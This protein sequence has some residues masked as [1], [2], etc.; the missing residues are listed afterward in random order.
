MF[1]VIACPSMN[2]DLKFKHPF[3]FIRSGP[4]GLGKTSFS[5]RFLQK[6]EAFCTE[7]EFGGSITWC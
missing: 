3:T 5:I 7:R 1:R 6:L 2:V 4:S